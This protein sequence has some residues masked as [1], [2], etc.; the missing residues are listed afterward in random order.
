M[1]QQCA[2]R[3]QHGHEWPPKKKNKRKKKDKKTNIILSFFFF[4]LVGVSPDAGEGPLKKAYRKKA[5][6]YHPDKNPVRDG[7]VLVPF[8]SDAISKGGLRNPLQLLAALT[9]R[10]CVHTLARAFSLANPLPPDRP[11][12]QFRAHIL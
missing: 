9:L 10:T 1:Q 12:F 3:L 2:N 5:M 11:A 7:H 8:V 4:F 6:K